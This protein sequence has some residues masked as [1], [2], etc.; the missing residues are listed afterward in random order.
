MKI[1]AICG[2]PAECQHHLI[3]GVGKRKVSDRENLVIDLCNYHHNL[4][5]KPEDRI[6]GNPVAE[7]LSKMLGQAI[8]ERDFIAEGGNVDEAREVFKEKFGKWYL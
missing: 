8:F 2:K 4:A 7:S 6:H 3:G 1:C 5:T